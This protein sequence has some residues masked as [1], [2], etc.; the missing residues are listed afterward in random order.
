MHLSIRQGSNTGE[1]RI[2]Y[3]LHIQLQHDCP[4]GRKSVAAQIEKEC[5]IEQQSCGLILCIS[6]EE[7][8][9][10]TCN[11]IYSV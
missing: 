7:I 4:H 2:I 11:I 9:N 6:V 5:I 1:I 10:K 8:R 3:S